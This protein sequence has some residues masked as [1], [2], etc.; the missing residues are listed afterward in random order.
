MS[1]QSA[2][3]TPIELR[4]QLVNELRMDQA[5]ADTA[6]GIL[7]GLIEPS[8]LPQMQYVLKGF[9]QTPTGN[10]LRLLAL[11]TLIEGFG[12]ESTDLLDAALF[13]LPDFDDDEPEI[14]ES[15]SG[16]NRHFDID[17][18]Q[19]TVSYINVGDSYVTTIILKD[20]DFYLTTL[21]DM[22]E[23]AEQAAYDDL[24]NM[25]DS[26]TVDALKPIQVQSINR[27]VPLVFRVESTVYTYPQND[28]DAPTHKISLNG[29][30]S[31]ADLGEALDKI[32]KNNKAMTEDALSNGDEFSIFTKSLTLDLD[33]TLNQLNQKLQMAPMTSTPSI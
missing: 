23:N 3:I 27:D 8:E 31:C 29:V 1:K 16:I 20:G 9:Y 25:K 30:V 13:E 12:V 22:L 19:A 7:L 6:T 33:A 28:P 15:A 2:P 21:G 10:E 14:D 18:H 17:D 5:N 32:V 11:N 4:D 26:I 24:H